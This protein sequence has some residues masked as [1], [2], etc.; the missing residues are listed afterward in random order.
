VGPVLSPMYVL[1]A[2]TS[3]KGSVYVFDCL[4]SEI[5]VRYSLDTDKIQST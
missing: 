1:F 4:F 3:L 2:E 5:C